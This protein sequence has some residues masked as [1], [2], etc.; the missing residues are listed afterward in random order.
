[1]IA[2]LLGLGAGIVLGILTTAVALGLIVAPFLVTAGRA[3]A[4]SAVLLG[5]LLA[6]VLVS[7]SVGVPL[8]I[9][10]R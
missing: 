4:R 3:T 7:G 2:F 8:L 1:M 10:R 6:L 9:A 5:G